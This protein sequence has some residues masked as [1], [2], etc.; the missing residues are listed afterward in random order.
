MVKC[1]LTLVS[2]VALSLALGIR[3]ASTAP[4]GTGGPSESACKYRKYNVLSGQYSCPTSQFGGNKGDCEIFYH[5]GGQICRDPS[6]P[7][8][9]A[10][11]PIPSP[12]PALH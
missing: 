11:Q 2:A 10:G 3:T 8:C 6:G 1:C 4:I 5:M 9:I 7:Y 12:S